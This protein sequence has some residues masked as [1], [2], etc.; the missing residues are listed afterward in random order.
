[1]P[2]SFGSLR[3][4]VHLMVS[5]PFPTFVTIPLLIRCSGAI[6]IIPRHFSIAMQLTPFSFPIWI[7]PSDDFVTNF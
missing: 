5:L 7:P 4:A 6:L 1:M 3:L 2:R